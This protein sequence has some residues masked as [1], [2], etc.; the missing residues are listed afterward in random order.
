MEIDAFAFD[1]FSLL[2]MYSF[3]CLLSSILRHGGYGQIDADQWRSIINQLG[4]DGSNNRYVD[5]FT[6]F[7]KAEFAPFEK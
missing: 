4:F 1:S 3:G 5:L 2:Q 7:Y 6:R